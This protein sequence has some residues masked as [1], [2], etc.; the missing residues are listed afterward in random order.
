VKEGQASI[1]VEAKA[2][3]PELRILGKP[4]HAKASPASGENHQRIAEAISEACSALA[5]LGASTSI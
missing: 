4:I 3:V 1:L 2:N 5:R